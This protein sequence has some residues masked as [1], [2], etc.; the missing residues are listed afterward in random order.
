MVAKIRIHGEVSMPNSNGTYGKRA[1]ENII[2]L[3]RIKLRDTES[4]EKNN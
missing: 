1:K 4:T 2:R 3:T